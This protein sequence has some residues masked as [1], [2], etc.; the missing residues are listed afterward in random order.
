MTTRRTTTPFEYYKS[1]ANP[2]HLAPA[3]INEIG[4]NGRANHQY[5]LTDFYAALRANKLP[6]VSFLKAASYQDG[7]AGY[8]DPLDEQHYI[9][10]VINALQK[11]PEWKSTAVVISYDDSDGWYDHQMSPIV[12]SSHD[13]ATDSITT[14]GNCGTGTPLGGYADRCGY[15]PRLPLMVI[16]PFSKT[17]YVDHSITDQSSILRFVEDNWLHRQRIGDGSFDA[18]AGSLNG[19]FDFSHPHAGRLLLNPKTGQPVRR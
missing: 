1:T 15:G 9:T 19:M 2:H 4:H 16:S 6:A 3:S 12:N 11:S 10:T 18:L 5:D 7:H 13:A 8:S 17:N 14:D